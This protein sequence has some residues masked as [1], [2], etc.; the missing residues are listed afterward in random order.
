MRALDCVSC[1]K[2]FLR[3][4]NKNWIGSKNA[5]HDADEHDA[6]PVFIA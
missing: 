1:S 5:E 3:A 4:G 2:I 6:E